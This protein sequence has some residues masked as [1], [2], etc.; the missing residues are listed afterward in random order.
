MRLTKSSDYALRLM[1]LLARSGEML[2]IEEA[3]DRLRAAEIPADEDRGRPRRVETDRVAARPRRRNRTGSHRRQGKRRRN[4]QNGGARFR[5]GGL[6][7]GRPVRLRVPAALQAH[8]GDDRRGRHLPQLPR[9]LHLVRSS[10]R[11]TTSALVAV[12]R[13][14]GKQYLCS[15]A[16]AVG[17]VTTSPPG[18]P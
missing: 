3:A 1:M 4:C 8:P 18:P 17:L 10:D 16:S 11:R 6:P 14:P 15:G 7:A 5:G 12:R 13:L 9:S 2:S